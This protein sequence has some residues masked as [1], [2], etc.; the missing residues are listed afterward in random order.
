MSDRNPGENMHIARAEVARPNTDQND[1]EWQRAGGA[2]QPE[3]ATSG[4]THEAG[5][6][7]RDHPQ[8]AQPEFKNARPAV[9]DRPNTDDNDIA[10]QRAGGKSADAGEDEG[11]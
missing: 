3:A 7:E 6:A 1:A 9:F 4:T 8:P 5:A 2:Q 10:W 11:E